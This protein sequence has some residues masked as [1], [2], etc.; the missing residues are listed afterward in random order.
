MKRRHLVV[1]VSAFTLLAV[2]FVMA[3]TV[4]VGVG[5]APGREQIRSLIQAQLGGRV[6]GRLHIG[7]VRGSLLTGFTL[8]TFAIRGP[9]DSL[10]V[11][12]GRVSVQYDPRDLIDRRILLRNV[13]VEHP[14]V[15]IRQYERGDWN[16]Q[17]IFGES[18]GGTPRVPGRSF[19]DYVVLDSVQ[20]RDAQFVLTRPWQPDD[21][22]AGAKRDSAIQVNLASTTREIR[23]SADGFTHT[24]R[25]SG[26]TALLPHVRLADPDSG[27]FGQE[28]VIASMR[29]NEQ[30]PPFDVRSARGVVRKLGDSVFVDVPHFDL[31]ASTGSAVAKIWWGGDLPIRLDIRVKGDSVSM[32]DVAWVYPTLPRTGGGRA[33]IHIYTNADNPHVFEYALSNMDVRST[34][35]RLT[36]AMTFVVGGPVL[37]VTGVDLRANPVNFDLLRALAGGPF[38]TDWQGDLYGYARGPGGP[39]THF[40]IDRSE[41]TWRDTHVPGAVSRF[42][43]SGELDIVQPG[44]TKFHAFRADAASLDLRS[45]EYLF[46]G[47]PRIG[48]TVA[49]TAVLDSSW[50]D[51][52]FSRADVVH[53]NGPGEPTHVNGNGRVTYGKSFMTYD[54]DVLAQP[55]SLTMLA[56]A[57]PLG[58]RGLLSG[59]IQVKGVTDSLQLKLDLSGPTGRVTYDGFVDAYPLG[60]AARGAGRVEGLDLSQLVAAARV[61][62][63]GLTGDYQLDVRGDTNDLATL[64]GNATVLLDRSQFDGVRV[65]PSRL[66]AR[67]ADGRIYVDTLRIESVAGTLSAGGALG[68]VSSVSDSLRY[69]VTVDSLGGLRRY[70]APFVSAWRRPSQTATS[71]DSLAGSVSLAGTIRGSVRGLA[72]SGRLDGQNVYAGRDAGKTVAGTFRL[73]GLGASPRGVATVRVDQVVLGGLALDTLGGSL[74]FDGERRGGFTLGSRAANGVTFAARGDIAV[75]DSGVAVAVGALTLAT[76]SSRWSLAGPVSIVTRGRG[77]SIDSLVLSNG[78]GGR[79][80][81]RGGVPDS[82]RAKF[83]F[84]AD[85]IALHDVGRVAQIPTELSGWATVTVQ[86]AGTNGA[87]VMNGQAMLSNVRYGGAR[88]E[89]VNATAEYLGRRAA[90]G[91]DVVNGGRTALIARA[92]L[93][94]ELR[95]FGARLLDDSLRGTLRTDSA[96]FDI[97]EAFVPGM[98]NATGSLAGDLVIGGTWKHPDLAG[99][100][101][102]ANGEVT[103]DALGI[104]VKGLSVDVGLFGHSDSLA[105]RRFEG[106]SGATAANSISLR[107]YVA[108]RD[109]ANPYVNLTLSARAFHALDKRA[110]AR[111]DV[112]TTG[113]GVRL[114]GRLRGATLTGGLVVDRGTI[115]LPDPALARKEVVDLSSPFADT[116]GMSLRQSLPSASSAL[117]ESI[118]I[119][120]VRVALGD[121][122]WLRSREAN[123]KLGGSLTVERTSR[124]RRGVTVGAVALATDDSL[125]LALDGELRAERGTY[126]LSLGPVQREFQVEGGTITFFGNSELAPVLNISALYTVHTIR[127]GNNE[128][129]RIRVR[130][131]GPLYPNPIVSLESGES[132]ALSQSD[133]VSYLIF[134]QPNF[135]LGNQ[136]QSYVQLAVQTLFPT[137]QTF[138]G[139]QLR[140]VLGSWA[141]IFQLRLGTSDPKAFT[142]FATSGEGF[143]SAFWTSRLGAEKQLSDNVYVSLSTGICQLKPQDQ[144]NTTS[145]WWDFY[146]GLSGKIEWRL[147]GTAAV[148]AGKEPSAQ[149]CGRPTIGRVVPTPSQWGVSLFKSWRF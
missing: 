92:S 9:D 11:S 113:N 149:I 87:P 3:V 140:S 28:F 69:Q 35:S 98:R 54:V 43:G 5:T 88:L 19:G 71:A 78:R 18:R 95:Y 17:R 24:Y 99:S 85:S 101:R 70:V 27:V 62:S 131:T 100:I 39:L 105:I 120:G 14:Y 46:P 64:R 77:I 145:Q 57:Y 20:V 79:I 1:L 115:F 89:R 104:R 91:V 103:L 75:R 41:L 144:T 29:V 21:S 16:F 61:P 116:I 93:P 124:Q 130:L 112:S 126:T 44:D 82:G 132:Y 108:Y 13:V 143:S 34:R 128:S 72:V 60:V 10:L 59:P 4:G 83:L 122:V 65:F 141:D 67:F 58:L 53:R 2:I 15:H 52:R 127:N 31:P 117:L 109:L 7:T 142:N 147:S 84:R 6:N 8:D 129:I 106:W 138:T 119:D 32:S 36:G 23:R 49:G 73:T 118:L 40:V 102:V 22:L 114:R 86:A 74:R 90:V 96:S 125:G 81:L 26:A 45:I 110:L 133:L 139:S 56:R 50:M 66:R 80:A 42:G 33:D 37:A 94:L 63:S 134:G 55:V 68:L 12:T 51:V 121:E 136:N 47:F 25:W 48:G 137:A 146:N 76:D 97:I 111:L 107:G 148:K 30:E 123:I 38:A 135:E